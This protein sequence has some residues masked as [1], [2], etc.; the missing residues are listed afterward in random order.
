MILEYLKGGEL[1]QRVIDNDDELSETHIA[2]NFLKQICTACAFLSE[3][4]IAH[5]DIKPENIMCASQDQ[6]CLV[7]VSSLFGLVFFIIIDFHT[8]S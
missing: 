5:L 7:K 3:R 6:N 8:Y 2:L 4:N 1:F